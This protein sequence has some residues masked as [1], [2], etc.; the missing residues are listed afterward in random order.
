MTTQPQPDNLRV[1]ARYTADP[2]RFT[3][4]VTMTE[5]LSFLNA[6]VIPV[7]EVYVQVEDGDS[8]SLHRI[9]TLR[10]DFFPDAIREPEPTLPPADESLT[11]D[12]AQESHDDE[13]EQ[14]A[15]VE[16]ETSPSFIKRMLG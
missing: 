7:R 12:S 8:V 10:V 15:P 13:I 3:A 9:G 2:T 11:Q 1:V 16:S 4:S 14:E 5:L 6:E